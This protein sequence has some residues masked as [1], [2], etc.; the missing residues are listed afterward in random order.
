MILPLVISSQEA[1]LLEAHR[2]RPV[3]VALQKQQKIGPLEAWA[4]AVPWLN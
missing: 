1:L 2:V 4:E 3:A